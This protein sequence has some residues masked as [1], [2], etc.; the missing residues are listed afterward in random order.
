MSNAKNH[1]KPIKQAK[2]AK[3]ASRG[4]APRQTPARAQE[5]ATARRRAAAVKALLSAVAAGLF[6]VAMVLSRHSFAGHAKEPVTAL[7]APP[8]F[9]KIV[10]KNLLQAG[11]VGPAQ[12][13]PGA[14]TAVS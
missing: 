8:K 7:A 10:K 12:A 4:T 3:H 9:V 11:I 1:R 6:G 5:L 13:P 14:A 2:P